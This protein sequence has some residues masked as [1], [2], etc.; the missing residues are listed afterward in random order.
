MPYNACMRILVIEPIGLHLGYLGCYG[1]EWVATPN[2]DR[3]ASQGIVFDNHIVDQPELEHL[4]PW[5]ER[6]VA[7]GVYRPPGGPPAATLSAI[8]QVIRPA[9]DDDWTERASTALRDGE[10]LVWLE[11]PSLLPPWRLDD[12]LLGVYFDEED[13]EE[14]LSPWPDPPLGL[15]R[16]ADDEVLSLQSTY[17]AVVTAFDAQLGKLLSEL[18]SLGLLDATLVCVTA[19]AGLP[20][21][22]HGMIGAPEPRLHDELVHV[23]L[24]LRLPGAAQAGLRCAEL[25][26]PID[27]MPTFL[28]VLGESAAA[29]RHGV[30]LAPILRGDALA[31][32]SH[33]IAAMR[34][35]GQEAWLL[36]TREAALHLPT[37][38]PDSIEPIPKLFL[39]PED[40]WEVNDLYVRQAELADALTTTL[41]EAIA[42]C[43][44][45]PA[46]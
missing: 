22:E 12:D 17:A 33:A 2:L 30:C 19:R 37:A 43:H 14:G 5:A 38:R 27:L 21:G 31:V 29:A 18:A 15:A 36:R 39:K 25:T 8:G 41:R 9:P 7:T 26:Q 4:T 45:A 42:A 3:L 16:L 46:T 34:V 6:S 23:P 10:R 32:R 28:D 44:P 24:V 11:G 40:R 35:E 13:V 20:L 1:N